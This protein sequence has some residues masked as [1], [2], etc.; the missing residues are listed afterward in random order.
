M[1]S[2]R[3]SEFH[4]LC[5]NTVIDLL[6]N[7]FTISFILLINFSHYRSIHFRGWRWLYSTRVV[8]PSPVATTDVHHPHLGKK[9]EKNTLRA[10]AIEPLHIHCFWL[11]ALLGEWQQQRY[12]TQ[13][14]VSLLIYIRHVSVVIGHVILASC[15]TRSSSP[16]YG[17]AKRDGFGYFFVHE[18]RVVSLIFKTKQIS[19]VLWSYVKLKEILNIVYFFI[20]I[21]V[22][23]TL[24][25]KPKSKIWGPFQILRSCR[26]ELKLI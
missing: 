10:F 13:I 26:I 25:S 3:P 1:S 21:F 12:C 20:V 15:F 17:Q 8:H 7:V 14:P 16:C 24:Y 11:T 23:G 5:I 9:D 19:L 4:L 22:E 6:Y 2:L 18:R